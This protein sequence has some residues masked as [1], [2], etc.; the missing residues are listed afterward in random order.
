MEECSEGLKSKIQWVKSVLQ[1]TSCTPMEQLLS[2]FEEFER[3]RMVTTAS[4]SLLFFF[5]DATTFTT[6][7]PFVFEKIGAQTQTDI[8]DPYTV[9][10]LM[11]KIQ[12][13]SLIFTH[14]AR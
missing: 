11:V 6:T 14:Q 5:N 8:S 7:F 2:S 9:F 4:H 13:L 12:P 10:S 1:I 3:S